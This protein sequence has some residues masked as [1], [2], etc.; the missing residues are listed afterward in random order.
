VVCRV[1]GDRV[2]LEGNCVFYLEGEIE[3]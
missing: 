1:A 3:I 2:L